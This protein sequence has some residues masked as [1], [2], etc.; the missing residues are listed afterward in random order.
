MIKQDGAHL[1][2]IQMVGL[3]GIQMAYKYLTTWHP[4]CFQPFEHQTSSVQWGSE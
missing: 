2:G 3:S 4:T 1:S